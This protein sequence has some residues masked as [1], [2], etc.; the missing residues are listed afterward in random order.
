VIETKLF[1]VAGWL[2][3]IACVVARSFEGLLYTWNPVR[4]ARAVAFARG[5]D[6]YTSPDSGVISGIIYGP[7]G[8]FLY[9]PAALWP[10]PLPALFTACLVSTLLTLGPAFVILNGRRVSEG[11]RA[12]VLPVFLVLVLHFYAS[13]ATAG[14]WMIHTDAG[15]LGLT[16]LAIYWTLQHPVSSAFSWR[17]AAAALCA[18]L[19]VWAKQTTAPILLLPCAYFAWRGS[20]AAAAWVLALTGLFA[21]GLGAVFSAIYGFED[22]WLTVFSVP[23]GH[24]RRPGAPLQEWR[25]VTE[26]VEMLYLLGVVVVA[27]AF[28][29]KPA[30]T[31]AASS[32]SAGAWWSEW[33][34]WAPD[35]IGWP[36]LLASALALLPMSL[37]GLMKTGGTV[38]NLGLVDYFLSLAVAVLFLRLAALPEFREGV[39]RRGLEVSLLLLLAAMA[40]RT[41][42]TFVLSAREVA[43][44]WPPPIQAAYEYARA[45]PGTT[46][47]PWH[48]LATLLAEDRIDHTAW[49][50]MERETAGFPVSV[51]HF[52]EGLPPR[53]ERIAVI[54]QLPL[55]NAIE[56]RD[57]DDYLLRRLPEFQCRVETPGLPGWVVLERGPQGCAATT[58]APLVSSR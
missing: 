48:P 38:N 8:F 6:L 54:D 57:W 31:G 15:A 19:A 21:V 34:A 53:L 26:F 27:M 32:P 7:V 16:C 22:L 24:A 18:A 37:L 44:R 35:W 58:P 3:I 33:S 17:L 51:T 42:A 23:S 56:A 10:T 25:S 40:L 14:V 47:F 11:A 49:G 30:S 52:R 28:R 46:Y 43:A 29:M 9:A 1:R 2:L 5:Y 36:F 45:N 12:W 41:G 4:L 13:R 20:R 50:V 55:M 39:A